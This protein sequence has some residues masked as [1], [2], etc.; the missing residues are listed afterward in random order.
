MKENYNKIN[1]LLISITIANRKGEK[2]KAKK[3][4]KEL[5]KLQQKLKEKSWK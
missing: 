4:D 3:L 1:E 2:E 5:F